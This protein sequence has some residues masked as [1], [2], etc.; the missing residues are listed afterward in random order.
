MYTALCQCYTESDFNPTFTINVMNPT[1]NI[2]G[3]STWQ[4]KNHLFKRFKTSIT[5][6]YIKWMIWCVQTDF[7]IIPSFNIY[8]VENV[9]I[10]NT[11]YF[12]STKLILLQSM[13]GS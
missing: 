7:S 4:Q 3:S 5:R 9:K 12:E 2:F 1:W 11:Q 6:Y 13:H 10:R 8:I